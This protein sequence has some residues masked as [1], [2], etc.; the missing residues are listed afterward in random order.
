[1]SFL[2]FLP[3]EMLNEINELR[4]VVQQVTQEILLIFTCLMI[5]S[6]KI[7]YLYKFPWKWFYLMSCIFVS[8]RYESC[9]DSQNIPIS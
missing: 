6:G 2:A 5:T 9:L 1:M 7:P 3:L 4:N 8:F